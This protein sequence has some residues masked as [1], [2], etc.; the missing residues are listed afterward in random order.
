MSVF[1]DQRRAI[2]AA[3]EAG[4]IRAATTVPDKWTPPGAFVGPGDP[5]VTRQ[6]DGLSFGAEVVRHLVTLVVARGTNDQRADELDEVILTA[7][8]LLDGLIDQGFGVG[9][10]QQPGQVSINGQRHFGVS[11]EVTAEINRQHQS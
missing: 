8:G 5:Y 6:A 10:V 7:L 1:A 3:L 9:D 4:G 2:V 11:I